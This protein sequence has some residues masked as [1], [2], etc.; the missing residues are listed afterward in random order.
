MCTTKDDFCYIVVCFTDTNFAAVFW[1]AENTV[2]RYFHDYNWFKSKALALAC[3][4]I[5]WLAI[6]TFQFKSM[7]ES[8]KRQSVIKREFLYHKIADGGE[9]SLLLMLIPF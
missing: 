1:F 7:K 6:T 9:T 5:Q 2:L 4:P 8:R 3:S